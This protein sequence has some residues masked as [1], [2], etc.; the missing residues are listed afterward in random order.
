TDRLWVA[1]QRESWRL[2]RDWKDRKS[3]RTSIHVSDGITTWL[4]TY[5]GAFHAHR[6]HPDSFPARNLLDPSW[7]AGYDWGRALPDIRNGRNVLV[8][9]ARMV[10]TPASGAPD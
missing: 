2:E 10:A 8:M 4:P 9:H 3:N 6:A 5:S 1:T 7:L